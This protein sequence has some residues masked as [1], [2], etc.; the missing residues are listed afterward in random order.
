MFKNAL[1]AKALV[2]CLLLL[3]NPAISGVKVDPETG[4]ITITK[5]P[6]ESTRKD[7]QSKP[8]ADPKPASTPKAGGP[9]RVPCG[10]DCT[11]GGTTPRTPTTPGSTRTPTS[12]GA[13]VNPFDLYWAWSTQYVAPIW[14]P[15][16]QTSAEE[17]RSYARDKAIETS[18]GMLMD[19]GRQYFVG[20]AWAEKVVFVVSPRVFGFL[21]NVGGLLFFDPSEI[22]EGPAAFEN[23]DRKAIREIIDR[24][25][26]LR[27]RER[28]PGRKKVNFEE[29]PFDIRGPYR[30]KDADGRV[31]TEQQ[32]RRAIFVDQ[33]LSKDDVRQIFIGGVARVMGKDAARAADAL[34]WLYDFERV[35]DE[36]LSQEAIDFLEEAT[37]KVDAIHERINLRRH[38]NACV[39]T[40]QVWSGKPKSWS[41]SLPG[42]AHYTSCQCPFPSQ[43]GA[44][45]LVNGIPARRAVGQVCVVDQGRACPMANS[46]VTTSFCTC[47]GVPGRLGQVQRTREKY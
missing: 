35:E 25:E 30:S 18:A 40:P 2:V 45:I 9:H 41:C 12:S 44:S 8:P 3:G 28:D 26:E 15:L 39:L 36:G 16:V 38:P 13:T 31:S 33:N 14:R 32:R 46:A 17:I 42:N 21:F 11:G 19:V 23:G 5:E 7:P 34:T 22:G 10:P 29:V 24:A 47:P 6:S 1:A 4:R 37:A 27:K 20:P 43:A